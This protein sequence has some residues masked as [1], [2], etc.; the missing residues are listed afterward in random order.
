MIFFIN[1][2]GVNTNHSSWAPKPFHVA[3]HNIHFLRDK[4][5]KMDAM[6]ESRGGQ[7][8]TPV[9]GAGNNGSSSMGWS[10]QLRPTEEN[11]YL[12]SIVSAK[13]APLHHSFDFP[14]LF[15]SL[16]RFLFLHSLLCPFWSKSRSRFGR[17][18]MLLG[19]V[20]SRSFPFCVSCAGANK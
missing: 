14:S 6:T 17:S 4:A 18:S 12:L 3:H 20:L 10:P 15:L 7:A 16:R 9:P 11:C 1:L 2:R 19:L 5:H 13:L 8:K